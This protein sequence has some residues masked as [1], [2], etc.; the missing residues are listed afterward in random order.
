MQSQALLREDPLLVASFPADLLHI[1]FAT[2]EF[3]HD[4]KPTIGSEHL[5]RSRVADCCFEEWRSVCPHKE[6]AVDCEDAMKIWICACE[7]TPLIDTTQ[8][9][10]AGAMEDADPSRVSTHICF[11]TFTSKLDADV[12]PRRARM[13]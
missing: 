6:F 9:V 5:M 13:F 10:E 12:G 7:N 1:S 4:S 2:I 11:L 3:Q 8:S